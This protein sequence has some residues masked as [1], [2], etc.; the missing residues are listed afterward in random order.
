[1]GIQAKDQIS[2]KQKKKAQEVQEAHKKL[3]ATDFISNQ[4]FRYT[5]YTPS[6][7]VPNQGLQYCSHELFPRSLVKNELQRKTSK[8]SFGVRSGGE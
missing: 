4:T 8:K 1:M 5:R 6:Q 3:G 7:I 2:Y